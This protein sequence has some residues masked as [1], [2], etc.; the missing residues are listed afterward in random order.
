MPPPASVLVARRALEAAA[1]R[2]ALEAAAERADGLLMVHDKRLLARA[3]SMSA[4]PSSP[5]PASRQ[6]S[7]AS[8]SL[9]LEAEPSWSGLTKYKPDLPAISAMSSETT[10]SLKERSLQEQSSP[11]A[12]LRVSSTEN[13]MRKIKYRRSN[14]DSAVKQHS[15]ST[16][17]VDARRLAVT[18]KIEEEAAR[19]KEGEED[20]YIALPKKKPA[21][22]RKASSSKS[23]LYSYKKRPWFIIDPRISRFI[24]VWDIITS[25]AL[26]FTVCVTPYEVAFVPPVSHAGDTLF[27]I[28]RVV[29]SIFFIDMGLQFVIMYQEGGGISGVHWVMEPRLI[30]QH[31]L[32]GWF[33]IDFLSLTPIAFDIL[34]IV[35]DDFS[36]LS[37]LLLFRVVRVLRLIKLIR[38]LRAA[39]L[40]K[41][42]ETRVSVNYGQLQLY[43]CLAGT[44]F[45]A[46]WFACFF[47]LATTFE[48]TK[49]GTWM[50]HFGYCWP[51]V[52]ATLRA[53]LGIRAA[54][55]YECVPDWDL[56]LA[57]FYWAVMVITG[58]GG[59]DFYQAAFNST[60]QLFITVLVISG[61]VLWTYVLAVFC[62][63]IANSNP[64]LSE[65]RHTMDDLNRLLKLNQTTVPFP[66]RQKL[67]EYFHQTKHIQVAAAGTRVIDQLSD[68]LQ[69]ELVLL[70]NQH[71]L[72]RIWFLKD[73]EVGCV[74]Q[75]A[76]SMNPLVFS[77]VTTPPPILAGGHVDEPARLRPF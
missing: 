41:R 16:E 71:W 60:E 21:T 13:S 4:V 10:S 73:V 65:F 38:L 11:P 47:S 19:N 54:D 70:I 48:D 12:L 5:T 20:G 56:Y 51:S 28:N 50:H 35:S 45:A 34:P 32:Y 77:Y 49:I 62:E 7:D 58:T 53:E 42:W 27:I 25:A 66:V 26:L 2:R 74:V 31:Y 8:D 46:H 72:K 43:S 61:A 36:D 52:N 3:N 55:N 57:C 37:S 33:T 23:Q 40:L 18:V 59:T 63:V 67:R 76:T 30:A 39:R 9:S 15:V 6:S 75:V 64:D 44:L 22:M 17:D 68:E 24:P 1:E 69:G 14:T 29:D